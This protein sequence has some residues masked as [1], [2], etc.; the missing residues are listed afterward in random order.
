[1]KNIILLSMAVMFAFALSSCRLGQGGAAEPMAPGIAVEFMDTTVHP[2][3]D[4]FRYVNGGWL[5]NNEIPDDR[6]RWGSFDELR[7]TTSDRVH[8]VLKEAINSGNYHSDSDQAKAALFYETAMDTVWL[9]KLGLDPLMPEINKIRSVSTLESLFDYLINSISNRNSFFYGFYVSPDPN[10]SDINSGF[11]GPGALGLPERDYYTNTDDHTIYIQEE[12]KKHIAVMLVFLGY[13]ESQAGRMAENIFGLERQMASEQMKKEERRNPLLR[14][15]PRSVEELNRLLPVKNW[16]RYFDG[17]GARDLDTVIVTDINYF[18]NLANVLKN[19]NIDVMKEY[20]VWTLL[21]QSSSFLTT[22]LERESF[23]FYGKIL[24]GTPAML[25]R[26]ERVLNQANRAMGEAIG[27]L[28]TDKYFP[29]QAKATAQEMVDNIL[30]AFGERIKRLEW[31]SDST[32][33]KALEKLAAFNVKIAYPDEWK[34]YEDLEIKG[35]EEGGSYLGNIRSVS[36]WNWE[37]DLAK[38]GQPVDKTEWFM[39]PQTVNAYYSPLYNE[40]VFPAAILQPPFY[41]YRAD[42]AVNYGGIGAVIGHEISHGFDDQGSRFDAYGN[43]NNWWTEGDRQRFEERSR[44]LVEQYSSYEPLDGVF[45]NGAYNLGENIGDLGGVNVAYDGL[46]LHLQEHGDPGLI[47]GFTQEQRFFI[48]W[49][50]IWRIKFREEA[51]RTYIATAPHSPGMY[52]A[53]GPLVNI[54]AFY[55]A[56]DIT[57]EH[58]HYKPRE[59]RAVIW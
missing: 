44:L 23:N 50:T 11:L 42:P 41:N 28:Y 31:M 20:M 48:S 25:P 14:N 58:E 30:V 33:D 55:D 37:E 47:D 59:R 13:D 2:G 57:E 4:F 36:Q 22:E 49:G 54:D 38:L 21:N 27:K 7:Q 16:S 46:Q 9:N 51:L 56:F 18:Q 34:S 39:P 52:R 26:W 12:Y 19:Q 35:K 15:N 1:M 5:D 17:I 6:S 3:D 53:F 10:N 43:L 40:I 45:L 8:A 24:S 32:K 29:P